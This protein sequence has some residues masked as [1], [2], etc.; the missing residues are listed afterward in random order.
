MY[1]SPVVPA[2]RTCK[3]VLL[4]VKVQL[5][6][7][8]PPFQMLLTPPVFTNAVVPLVVLKVLVATPDM[9]AAVKLLV[10]GKL[11]PVI[12]AV[13]AVV[14][15]KLPLKVLLIAVKVVGEK[16]PLLAVPFC[17]IPPRYKV[18]AVNPL[19]SSANVAAIVLV[20]EIVPKEILPAVVQSTY[21][22]PLKVALLL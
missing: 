12:V 18:P 1:V 3:L 21:T 8:L 6:K 5:L 13:V 11:L 22:L 15:V 16:L 10:R 14:K 19:V 17:V 2:R 7:V 20:P 4:L 9:L